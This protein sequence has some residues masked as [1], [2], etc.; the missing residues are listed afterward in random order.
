MALEK[1]APESGAK[2]YQDSGYGELVRV[3]E[4]VATFVCRTLG[5]RIKFIEEGDRDVLLEPKQEGVN[6]YPP[7]KV[8]PKPYLPTT[9]L[10]ES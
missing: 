2:E 10:I 9:T 5:Y 1:S 7:P 3:P 6:R 4:G 8:I